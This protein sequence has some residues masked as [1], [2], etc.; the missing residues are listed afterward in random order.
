MCDHDVLKGLKPSR[1]FAPQFS[2]L[3]WWPH[4]H[5]TRRCT[6]ISESSRATFHRGLFYPPIRHGFWFVKLKRCSPEQVETCRSVFERREMP[7]WL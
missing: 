6:K 3:K 7:N 4:L 5:T 2:L 1:L